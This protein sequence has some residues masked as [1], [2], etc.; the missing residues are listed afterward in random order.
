MLGF[1]S[2]LFPPLTL[3]G[4]NIQRLQTTFPSNT[5]R[6]AGLLRHSI[7]FSTETTSNKTKLNLKLLSS[8]E[9]SA[10]QKW[11]TAIEAGV[12]N[13]TQ[14]TGFKPN[15]ALPDTLSLLQYHIKTKQQKKDQAV[16]D[17][18]FFQ[19][20]K[21][22]ERRQFTPGRMCS[23]YDDNRTAALAL[24]H[25]ED[26][27]L[28]K[29]NDTHSL[30]TLAEE[31]LIEHSARRVDLFFYTILAYYKT[32][33]L[34][35]LGRTF[36]QHGRG[37]NRLGTQACHSSFTPSLIDETIYRNDAHQKKMK[38]LL[39]G[40]HL[41][42]S[43]NS[44]VELPRFINIF[45]SQLERLCRPKCIE[46][47]YDVSLGNNTPIEGLTHFLQMMHD[48]LHG[49]KPLCAQKHPLRFHSSAVNERLLNLVI[50]GTLKNT[51]SLT[52]R[53][54]HDTYI[55]LLLRMSTVEKEQCRHNPQIYQDK[56]LS[57]QAEILNARSGCIGRIGNI[58]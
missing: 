37:N 33:L 6:T 1:F 51:F 55:Q 38:G 47:L 32:T 44:T 19:R 18:N 11:N 5:Y 46:I 22:E 50:R 42:E 10:A 57:M 58:N 54:V 40:T 49:L 52:T 53:S 17:S 31:S 39:S 3:L 8:R 27:L 2:K 43:L 16:S 56:M 4:G 24:T 35:A 41:E 12:R 29:K 36:L 28:C 20:L 15:S 23:T 14:H 30:L 9:Y 34:P 26:L 45:D 7:M 13:E 25:S 48:I 21:Q